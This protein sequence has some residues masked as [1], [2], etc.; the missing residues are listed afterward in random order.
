MDQQQVGVA[1][2]G[3][4]PV[5]RMGSRGDAVRH[6]QQLLNAALHAGLVEDGDFGPATDR[7][8][9]QFQAARGLAV[10]GIVGPQT[11]AAL[12]GSAPPSQGEEPRP[13]CANGWTV[14]PFGSDLR[15]AA[16][17]LVRASQGFT[18]LF[19]VPDIRYFTGPEDNNVAAPR[20]VVER[21]YGKVIYIDDRSF[22]IRFLARRT[23]IGAGVFAV[24]PFDSVGFNS[25]DWIGFETDS[26]STQ[27]PTV[28]GHWPADS[29]DLV[30][31]NRLPHDIVGCL[32]GT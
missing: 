13:G 31:G 28:P 1:S 22:R 9:R 3:N 14:P 16:L 24:A 18:G 25:P 15:K 8:V 10:D 32:D 5:L 7:A 29:Y 6:L 23:A 21:W 27:Y 20:P 4:M 2:T 12:L 11:W 19:E 30:A 17:D 26:G